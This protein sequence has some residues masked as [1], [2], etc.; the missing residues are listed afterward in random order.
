MKT[1]RLL[2]VAQCANA[3]LETRRHAY[4][5]EKRIDNRFARRG[6]SLS[7]LCAVACDRIT[8]AGQEPQIHVVKQISHRRDVRGV[9]K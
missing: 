9:T 8:R 2:D 4:S 1:D 5:H 3:L 6:V 7:K